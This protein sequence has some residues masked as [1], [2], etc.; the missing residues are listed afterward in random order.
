MNQTNED[1]PATSDE[2]DA[3]A[4]PQAAS[5]AAPQA[6]AGEVA[7]DSARL[8]AELGEAQERLRRATAEFSN[9]TKR[10][11]QRSEDDR[12]FAVEGFIR[13]ILPV[14]DALHSAREGLRG[15]EGTIDEAVRRGL[16]L[17]ENQLME[18]LARHG[19][20]RIESVAIPFDPNHH[21]ALLVVAHRELGPGH[22]ARELRPGFTM[23]GRVIRPAQVEVVGGEAAA[24]AADA[25]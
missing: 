1:A 4:A 16:D 11:R 23:H 13:D 25:G 17:V 22:V 9:E 6:A 19:V 14:F 21:E 7:A 20:R 2:A 8:A 10:I 18:V 3:G 15:R 12:K 24:G 5:G